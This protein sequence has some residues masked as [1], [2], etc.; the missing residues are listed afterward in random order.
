MTLRRDL[1]AVLDAQE[2]S[3]SSDELHMLLADTGATL[4]NI[5]DLLHYLCWQG[6]VSYDV[7]GFLKDGTRTDKT[8]WKITKATEE[9][10]FLPRQQ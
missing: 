5:D 10:R 3:Q 2:A 1:L 6:Y 7:I 8:Y 9:T 4:K